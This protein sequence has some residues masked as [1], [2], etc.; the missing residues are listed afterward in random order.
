M[1]YSVVFLIIFFGVFLFELINIKGAKKYN[2]IY[3]YFCFLVLILVSGL[4]FR[5]APDSVAYAYF[6]NQEYVYLNQLSLKYF[7]ESRFLPL[8]LII[9]SICKEL[10]GYYT[11]QFLVSFFCL[12]SVCIF[13]K[14]YS[15]YPFASTMFFYIFFYHYFSMEILREAVAISLF[16][17]AVVSYSER[18]ILAFFL[19]SCALLM[20]QF[21]FV[22]L[23]LYIIFLTKFS[24]RYFKYCFCILFSIFFLI[25]EPLVLLQN[26][27]SVA[28]YIDLSFYDIESELSTLG[29]INYLVKIIVPL[30]IIRSFIKQNDFLT[31]SERHIFYIM[32]VFYSGIYAIRIVSIPYI[33]RFINYASVFV[34]IVLSS[35][36]MSKILKFNFIIRFLA[37]SSAVI[38][39][40]FLSIYPLLKLDVINGNVPIYKRYYPYSSIL[41]KSIDSERELIIKIEAKE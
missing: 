23:I 17:L 37:F 6:F 41:E 31:A 29:L 10:G 35:F 25:K 22:L 15:L 8:W 7:N 3:L 16:L 13:I 4:R 19:I 5:L 32:I 11:F 40:C 27:L 18:K 36:L 33:E 26:M 12:S 30:L 38:L 21:A 14:K 9:C 20:H 39:S 24:I 34:I 1:T 28:G 2:K